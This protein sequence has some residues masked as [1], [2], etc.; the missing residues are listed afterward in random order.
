[1][2]RDE[3]RRAVLAALAHVAPDADLAALDPRADL[4]EALDLDSMDFLNF[5]LALHEALHVEI[6]EREYR[7]FSTVEDA[8][9]ALLA[10]LGA[11][12]ADHA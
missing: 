1:M 6:A 5:V 8:I 7:A 3:I 4:R 2:T 10:K 11:K 9:D 12:T